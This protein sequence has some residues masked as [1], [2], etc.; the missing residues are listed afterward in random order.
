MNHPLEKLSEAKLLAE[1]SG[2]EWI[3][4]NSHKQLRFAQLLAIIKMLVIF[5]KINVLINKNNKNSSGLGCSNEYSKGAFF[6]ESRFV[7]NS[8][9]HQIEQVTEVISY[10]SYF[11][12]K[13]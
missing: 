13:L 2:V 8:C 12:W 7:I 5:Y 9:L 10:G 11:L 6:N 3:H 4:N 1:E